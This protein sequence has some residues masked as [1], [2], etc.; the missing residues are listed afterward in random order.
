MLEEIVILKK[1]FFECWSSSGVLSDSSTTSFYIE[2]TIFAESASTIIQNKK[3]IDL[4]I[5]G[6]G[7]LIN[8]EFKESK[9]SNSKPQIFMKSSSASF[10]IK[11]CLFKKMT[12]DGTTQI[13]GS[14]S[15]TFLGH[16]IN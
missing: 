16:Q 14:G 12:S 4:T 9:T 8:C 15:I 1:S 6:K 3:G 5:G 2:D 10:I 13:S 7:K 11:D